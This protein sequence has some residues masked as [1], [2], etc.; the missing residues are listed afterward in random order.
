MDCRACLAQ[1]RTI[2]YSNLFIFLNADPQFPMQNRKSAR[3]LSRF[4]RKKRDNHP[5]R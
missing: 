1:A 5:Y 3:H 4:A 2:T